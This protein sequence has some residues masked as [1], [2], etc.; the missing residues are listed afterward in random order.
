MSYP[1]TYSG[2]LVAASTSASAMAPALAPP[3]RLS[4]LGALVIMLPLIFQVFHY[5]VDVPPL[6][7]VSKALPLL[8]SPLAIVA[9]CFCRLPYRGWFV[10]LGL[11]ALLVTPV[12]SALDFGEGFSA[13]LTTQI[14][15]LPITYY[16]AFFA[17]LWVVQPT[18][19]ELVSA[20]VGVGVVSLA[21]LP[22]LWATVPEAAYYGSDEQTKLFNFEPLRGFRI[23]LPTY[24]IEIF[25]LYLNRRFWVTKAPG[26]LLLMALSFVPLVLFNK[27]RAVIG[28]LAAVVVLVG[29]AG[30]PL[31]RKVMFV[32]VAAAIVI[33]VMIFWNVSAGLAQDDSVAV[34][35]GSYRIAWDALNDQPLG[36]LIG[37]GT[38]SH[39]RMESFR[40]L[41]GHF[42]YLADIGLLGVVYEYG[43]IGCLLF[44]TI[45]SKILLYFRRG[46]AATRDP[47]LFA[48]RDHIWFQLLTA[49]VSPIT[50][51]PAEW[52]AVLALFVYFRRRIEQRLP[53][54]RLG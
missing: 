37:L 21:L 17:I 27:E 1:V 43:L 30:Q 2:R 10:A 3:L 23:T 13:T 48:F 45:Y 18:Y 19:D 29:L 50:Y 26:D 44:L 5:I 51:A 36:W 46:L 14:K 32:A 7:A 16:F 35:Q 31:R 49:F 54:P 22:L 12:V 47:F 34:R 20:F 33:C 42:F 4:R 53:L 28:G 9:F 6:Y 24:F 25:I 41:Y 38:M 39:F 15:L 52:A 8:L 40:Q 11:Y